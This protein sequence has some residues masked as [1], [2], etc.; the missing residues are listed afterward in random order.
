ML[1]IFYGEMS[2]VIYNTSIYFKNTYEDEWITDP[3]T[4]E[5]ILD[6]DKSSV[7]EGS[8]ID[9]PVMGKI[10]PT[11]LSGGVKTLILMKYEPD[12]IWNASACGD[13]CAKWI[14]KIA[15]EKE[16]TINL[17]HIMDF[18]SGE[19]TIHILNTDQIVHNM[20]E[21]IWIAGLYV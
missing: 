4:K 11:S 17:R 19:F 14:L 10:P 1:H 2:D 5:M 15:E 7:L 6:I 13:N 16:L 12:K 21:L 20:K 18:G 9:S 3:F 8:V